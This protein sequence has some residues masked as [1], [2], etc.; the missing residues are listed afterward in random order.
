MNKNEAVEVEDKEVIMNAKKLH[1]S[2]TEM[3]HGISVEESQKLLDDI[4][5][6]VERLS[7]K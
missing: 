5:E 4:A 2:L 3:G 1:K 6:T 7:K